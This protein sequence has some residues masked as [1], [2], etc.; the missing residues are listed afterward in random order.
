MSALRIKHLASGQP[1]SMVTAAGLKKGDHVLDCTMGM[2]ADAIVA[3]F[4]VGDQGRVV[5]LESEPVI[6]AITGHGL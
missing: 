4:V 6:A 1:D 5:S 2:G 3:S